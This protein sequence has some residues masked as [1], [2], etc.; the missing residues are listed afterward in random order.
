M[1]Q[2]EADA[3]QGEAQAIELGLEGM[4]LKIGVLQSAD[5]FAP[6]SQNVLRLRHARAKAVA[7]LQQ[8][9]TLVLGRL[10]AWSP[11]SAGEID[12][13]DV[14]DCPRNLLRC[15]MNACEQRMFLDGSKASFRGRYSQCGLR[16]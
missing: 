1:G 5:S 10:N 7:Q 6:G 11:V 12:C 4:R 15:G 13:N 14:H 16:K 3:P 8:R 2:A 9:L